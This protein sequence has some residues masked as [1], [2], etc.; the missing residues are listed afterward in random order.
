MERKVLILSCGTGEGHNSTAYAVKEALDGLDVR[1][2]ILDPISL[3]SEKIRAVVSATYNNVIKKIPSAFG[4]VYRLGAF[5]DR[6]PLPSP[7]YRA[8]SKYALQ[9]YNYIIDNGFTEVV[10]THI[11]AMDAMT[12]VKRLYGN[13]PTYGVLTDYVVI[14]FFRDSDLDGYFVGTED[15]KA[16][17]VESGY[18]EKDIFSTGIPVKKGFSEE[19]SATTAKS[20]LHIPDDKR[21]ITVMSGGVGCGNLERLCSKLDKNFDRDFF[22][23]VLCGRNEKLKSDLDKK[24]RDSDKFRTVSFTRDAY[25]YVK[26]SEMVLTK[27]GGLSS[28]EIAVAGVP[29]VH[30]KPI[31]GCETYNYR[32]FVRNGLSMPGKTCRQAA[33]SARKLADDV[34]LRRYVV[35]NQKKAIHS[36]SAE[37][38][39]ERITRV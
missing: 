10:C 11:F 27:P 25:L 28:T 14:P 1:S 36:D 8:N 38:I 9:L 17:L 7:V 21:V 13:V 12:A 39:A 34:A 33:S 24:Y 2:E 30:L 16:T 4:F 26:A 6:L 32:Y 22:I 3:K 35:D 31:P 18:P 37:E 5:Y 19:V 20:L 29:L 15:L 23:C